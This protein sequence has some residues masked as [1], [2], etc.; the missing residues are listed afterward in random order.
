MPVA[1]RAIM[2][3]QRAGGRAA[4]PAQGAGGEGGRG[5]TGGRAVH[6]AEGAAGRPEQQDP[7]FLTRRGAFA[8]VATGLGSTVAGACAAPEQAAPPGAKPGRPRRRRS[9]CA[10]PPGGR[11]SRPSGRS[12]ASSRAATPASRS[13]S[14]WSPRSS[15]RRWRPRWSPAPGATPRSANNG[16][17]VKWMEGGHHL[18]MADRLKS[19]GINLE[20]DWSLDGLEIWEGKVLHMP[21]DNDPRAHLLQQDRLQG[22]RRQGPLGRPQGELDHRRH[23]RGRQE[24]HQDRGRQDHP[25][26]PAVELHQLPGVQPA[27]LGAGRQLRR[28]GRT[29]STRSR[30]R[31]SSRPTRCC[32]SGPRRTRSSSPRRRTTDLM[33]AGGAIPFRAG[34]AAMYHRAAYEVQLMDDVIKD[35]FEW[36]VAPLPNIDDKHAGRAGH[37]GQPE[38]RPGQDALPDEAVRVA[39]AAGRRALPELRRR[40]QAV[41]A[42]RTRRPGRRTRPPTP[43]ASTSS[44]SSSTSTAA[45]TASTSTTPA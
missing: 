41:R 3:I 8:L 39:E 37:L 14:S 13:T 1:Y 2:R 32:S 43:R 23:G 31:R 28:A 44:R 21:F 30:T 7:R 5:V 12:R 33:G 20:D 9:R 11:R 24:A 34:V 19:D 27:R 15:S 36:D 16:V 6:G 38:L 29:S 25:L 10:S 18:D 35:K 17:Q 42:G 40:A 26:R 45:R 4:V 22:S